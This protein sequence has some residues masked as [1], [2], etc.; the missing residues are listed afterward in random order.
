MIILTMFLSEQNL[1]ER[2]LKD[3]YNSIIFRESRGEDLF[4]V[5]GYVRD[6]LRGINSAD[7]D[8]IVTGNTKSFVS[9][10]NEALKGT[11]VEFKKGKLIRLYLKNG[12]TF[13]IS[14]LA[15]SLEEDLSKRDFTI[16]AIAWSP[17][18]GLVDPCNGRKDLKNRIVRSLSDENMMSD[19][20]RLVRAYR[21]ASELNGTIERR[22]RQLIKVIHTMIEKIAP[23][24]ITSE[25]YNI[26]NSD[27]PAKYLKMA[28]CD[29]VLKTILP[30]SE[31]MLR[32]NLKVI[33]TMDGK[34][35]KFD[36]KYKL[37][38]EKLFSQNL[39]FKGL[40]HLE[41]LLWHEGEFLPLLFPKVKLSNKM[42]RR[43]TLAHRGMS[44][45]EGSSL[46]DV[47]CDTK[48]SALDVLVIKDRMDLLKEYE[49]FLNVWE[50]GIISPFEIS[51]IFKIRGVKLGQVIRKCRKEQF[52]K[53]ISTKRDAIKVINGILHNISYQT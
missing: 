9:K 28:L 20:L 17:V 19:P 51:E 32:A 38:L 1:K 34:L 41:I 46:F 15:G 18:C 47:F 30:I 27:N 48:E 6:A 23:E 49:R 35:N 16:N 43:I 26:L 39:T 25:L 11:I 36:G 12:I 29:S 4:L 53:R 50:R 44:E 10:I 40:L 22:S 8:Y 37:G 45:F 3:R 21:F 2:I 31:R 33:S 5:G 42:I 7:R 14:R 52:E 24:R 13:D